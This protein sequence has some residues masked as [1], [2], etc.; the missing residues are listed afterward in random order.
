MEKNTNVCNR[1]NKNEKFE[2]RRNNI[3]ISERLEQNIELENIENES[4]METIW[5]KGKITIMEAVQEAHGMKTI[6]ISK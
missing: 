3:F 5:S 6:N 1:K 4:N 2:R